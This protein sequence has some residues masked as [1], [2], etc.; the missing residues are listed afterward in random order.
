MILAGLVKEAAKKISQEAAEEVAKKGLLQKAGGLLKSAWGKIR[1]NPFKTAAGVAAAPVAK[2]GYDLWKWGSGAGDKLPWVLG[3]AAVGGLFL[4]FKDKIFGTNEVQAVAPSASPQPVQTLSPAEQLMQPQLS[5]PQTAV[6]NTVTAS[7]PAAV[8]DAYTS[9]RPRPERV[10]NSAPQVV[11]SAPA[12]NWQAK[13]GGP[14]PTAT[15]PAPHATY[16]Q[17]VALQAEQAVIQQ[18]SVA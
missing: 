14:K 6:G 17:D 18:N 2:D 11:Q 16:A 1:G 13:V 15:I 5:F 12:T 3:A 8:G 10:D 4:A 9:G 7:Y